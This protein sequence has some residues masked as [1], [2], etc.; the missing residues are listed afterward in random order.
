MMITTTKDSATEDH[1][2]KRI[3]FTTPDV[4]QGPSTTAG[5]R[6]GGTSPMENAK[7]SF[8]IILESL[9]P[10]I[11]QLAEHYS[12]KF[13]KLKV[14]LARFESTKEK[15]ADYDF[16]P[17]SARIKF[18]LG[19]SERVKENADEALK[20][21]IQ[22]I[23]L[24]VCVFQQD[25]KQN[26]SESVDLEIKVTQAELVNT[27]CA[28]VGSLGIAST[29][30]H[31]TIDKQHAKTLIFHTIENHE[32]LLKH[33]GTTFDDFF[34]EFKTATN[35]S[36][37]EYEPFT[38]DEDDTRPVK[39][40]LIP[41][42]SLLA[43]LFVRSWDVYCNTV[44]SNKLLLETKEFVDFQLKET[45]TMDAVMALDDNRITEDTVNNLVAA[46]V[47]KHTKQLQTKLDRLTNQ[48]Q[49]GK[50]AKNKEG[51]A[52]EASAPTKKNKKANEK[53]KKKGKS[54]S[55]KAADPPAAAAANGT[56]NGKKK[57]EEKNSKKKNNNSKKNGKGQ[58][59]K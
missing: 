15:L 45:A 41:F 1:P 12:T 40:L 38:L 54:K 16:I 7:A 2:N 26:I 44:Y 3:R 59:K 33:S 4:H 53:K 21:L 11:K 22:R 37:A 30:A 8:T 52:N 39:D 32:S 57:K 25:L 28:A 9:P 51:G 20:A 55:N 5:P 48:L 56:K 23:D 13:L 42:K 31:P 6:K 50:T 35:D 47:T 17:T 36:A 19:A 18:K 24:Q 49:S 14:E 58:K 29:L 43:A 46:Q 34:S 10:A 27:F